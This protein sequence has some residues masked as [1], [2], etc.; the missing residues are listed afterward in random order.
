MPKHLRYLLA[1]LLLTIVAVPLLR[2]DGGDLRV[3]DA[4]KRRDQKT[5]TVLLRSKADINAAQP[6]APRRWR[7]RFI[8]ASGR[9]PKPC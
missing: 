7:G 6:M 2:A 5:F 3:L 8:W 9:W 4:V 1:G